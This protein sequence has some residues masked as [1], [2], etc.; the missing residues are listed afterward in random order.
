MNG[1]MKEV[2]AVKSHGRQVFLSTGK[3]LT[4]TISQF[5]SEKETIG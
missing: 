5:P 1:E 3:I 2:R 4:L